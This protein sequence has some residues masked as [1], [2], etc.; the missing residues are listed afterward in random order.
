MKVLPVIAYLIPEFPG[1]THI[2]MWREISHL[3]EWGVD[4]RLFSTRRPKEN[5]RARHRFADAAIEQTKYIM[6]IGVVT[7][8]MALI[9][10]ICRPGRAISAFCLA[11]DLPVDRK[12]RDRPDTAK[13]LIP[14]AILSKELL[15]AGATHLHIHSCASAAILGMLVKRLTDIPYS[16]TLNA[17]LGWWGGAMKQKLESADFTIVITK[18]LLE[19]VIAT[20]PTLA[21]EQRL[22]GRIGVDTR[23]YRP[24]TNRTR[25]HRGRAVV[26][27]AR[28]HPSK[29]HDIL[30]R[31]ISKLRQ[32][33]VDVVLRIAGAG[34]AELELREL[35]HSLKVEDEVTFL[36]SIGDSE[37]IKELQQ[38]DVFVL[39]SHAEPLG[40]AYMEAMSCALATIGTDAGGVGEI[41]TNEQD[42]ILVP[43]KD[44]DV[45]ADAIERLLR[46]SDL[47][48]AISVRGRET[49]IAKFDSRIGAAT[50]YER[51]FRRPPPSA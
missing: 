22:L 25:D 44:V 13:L 4:V 50:L 23:E 11:K 5:E 10:L 51:L 7:F 39:A 40:V 26:T 28:L 15:R 48:H 46:D 31:A 37:V 1:Q 12:G 17:D 2:W 8:M 6:P 19:E 32:R 14:A 16:M 3:R 34:P 38:A 33:N 20:Y 49:I 42:G 41:I 35:A 9:W 29:G 45:L 24:N 27:V 30:I 43:P 21:K 36:G 18:R 47:R